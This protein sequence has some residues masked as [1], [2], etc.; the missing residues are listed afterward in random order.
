LF[1]SPSK[2]VKL[3]RALGLKSLFVK[4][5]KKTAHDCSTF[6]LSIVSVVSAKKRTYF[7]MQ[8][9]NTEEE[10]QMV[11]GCIREEAKAQEGLYRH[12]YGYGMGIC[13]RYAGNRD[14]A[15]EILNEGFLKAFTKIRKY[16][17][18]MPFKSWLRK[19]LVN[20]AI[21]HF[22]A[23]NRA[24]GI[25]ASISEVQTPSVDAG[26]VSQ[27]TAQEILALMRHLPE[28]LRISF[29]LYEIEGYNHEEIGK[30][31]GIPPGT[32]RSNLTRAKKRLRELVTQHFKQP[33]SYA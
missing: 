22:R 29:N 16:G 20:T 21:D 2:S 32:S 4:T 12:F 13:L 14:E 18:D 6:H 19:I 26:V 27:L 5:Q 10:D 17:F 9:P 7:P 31:L 30:M 25:H 8:S 1:V 24:G 11:K 33:S 3:G 23:A 28:A 15:L